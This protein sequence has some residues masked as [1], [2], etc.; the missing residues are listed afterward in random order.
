MRC[1]RN[2]FGSADDGGALC[3]AHHCACSSDGGSA[4]RFSTRHRVGVSHARRIGVFHIRRNDIRS[5]RTRG[6]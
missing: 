1:R 3:P 6:A 4:Y 5:H 2:A